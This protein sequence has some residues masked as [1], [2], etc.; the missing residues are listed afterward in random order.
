[1]GLSN[2]PTVNPGSLG[3]INTYA[4]ANPIAPVTGPTRL[5]RYSVTG[6]P[7]SFPLPSSPDQYYGYNGSDSHFESY[8]YHQ[9]HQI[10]GILGHEAPIPVG[11]YSGTSGQE[12]LREWIPGVPQS[13]RTVSN[14]YEEKLHG[15]SSSSLPFAGLASTTTHETQ[16]L[17]PAMSALASNLPASASD[18]RV[19]PTPTQNSIP[20]ISSEVS[21][22][23]YNTDGPVSIK[24]D[25]SWAERSGSV[26]LP[27]TS[28]PATNASGRSSMAYPEDQKP[29]F[30]YNHFRNINDA[31]SSESS[32]APEYAFAAATPTTSTVDEEITP[33]SAFSSGSYTYSMPSSKRPS[34]SEGMLLSG[35]RY[36]PLPHRPLPAHYPYHHHRQTLGLHSKEYNETKNTSRTPLA[37][38]AAS[39]P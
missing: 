6:T 23:G 32:A 14:G 33:A 35:Q 31:Q 21:G 11:I 8:N 2:A 38:V 34:L 37:T 26:S 10:H 4:A 17:F 25:Y 30:P 7:Y 22:Q 19:L 13:G 29:L 39:H 15:G 18:D 24:S 1:M 12:Q 16:P 5:S 36:T 9:P 20:S 28:G 3:G 27:T